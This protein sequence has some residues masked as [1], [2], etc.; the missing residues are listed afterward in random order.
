MRIFSGL[1]AF[2]YVFLPPI[3]HAE[4]IEWYISEN[5]P[6]YL[7]YLLYFGTSYVGGNALGFL[8]LIVLFFLV[9]GF[10]YLLFIG[11][12]SLLTKKGVLN[13]TEK[14]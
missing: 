1:L 11:I 9:W 8:S 10:L 12:L 4:K 5:S 14:Y 6:L 7:P 2:I 3:A 13:G